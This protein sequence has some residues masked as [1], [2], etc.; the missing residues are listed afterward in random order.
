[1]QE[2]S[3]HCAA[4]QSQ[5]AYPPSAEDATPRT[6][7]KVET[8]RSQDVL[9]QQQQEAA[10]QFSHMQH[11]WQQLSSSL[12]E[13]DSTS[14]LLVQLLHNSRQHIQTHHLPLPDDV[15]QQSSTSNSAAQV[16]PCS[17]PDTCS[18]NTSNSSTA[19]DDLQ[20]Q[21]SALLAE[22]HRIEADR[23]DMALQQGKY[24]GTIAQ[25]C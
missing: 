12:A 4:Q 14:D 15:Q 16:Q 11:S 3:A 9:Q 25:V 24:K 6:S 20:Q 5:D 18:S 1:M 17:R 22:K 7:D 13:L 19:V 2:T 10:L 8:E 23:Q 21:L